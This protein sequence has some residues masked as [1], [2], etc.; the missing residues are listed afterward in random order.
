M[1]TQGVDKTLT[2]LL[3]KHREKAEGHLDRLLKTL[4]TYLT[5]LGGFTRDAVHYVSEHRQGLLY[6]CF[7]WKRW[8]HVR[9]SRPRL[10]P[11]KTEERNTDCHP[12]LVAVELCSLFLLKYDILV[13]GLPISWHGYWSAFATAAHFLVNSAT[14]ATACWIKPCTPTCEPGW[15]NTG[16]RVSRFRYWGNFMIRQKK[17]KWR[18]FQIIHTVNYETRKQALLLWYYWFLLNPS[19]TECMQNKKKHLPLVQVCG[20]DSLS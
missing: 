18:H 5:W 13:W 12:E 4:V 1:V 7:H 3:N 8:H 6:H 9:T 10:I 11:W 19:I 16:T 14:A 20:C 15:G 2:W 17:S